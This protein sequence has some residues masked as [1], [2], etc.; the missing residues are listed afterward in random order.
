VA[1]RLADHVVLTSDNPRDEDPMAII[2][3]IRAGMNA[4]PSALMPGRREAVA[5]ACT[6]ARPGDVVLIAGKGHET[7][8]EI[9]RVYH[10]FDD[11]VV[12]RGIVAELEARHVHA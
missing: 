6:H 8:Q 1:E 5:F 11:R 2:N 4:S 10:D 12:A 7:Y 9:N 3:D